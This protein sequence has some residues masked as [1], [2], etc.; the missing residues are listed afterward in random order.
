MFDLIVL[1]LF[2][3]ILY[4][5]IGWLI[6]L[7]IKVFSYLDFYW[8]TS[9]LVVITSLLLYRPELLESFQAILLC[10]LYAFWSMRLS[11]HLFQRI[12]KTGEDSRYLTLKKKWKIMY[13]VYLYGLF[14]G[15]A[16]LT[17][18]LSI[19]LFLL[20]IESLTLFN[21]LGSTL[22]T[23]ALIGEMI[24]DRQLKSFISSKNNKGKVC[25]I[26]LW[27]YSRHPNYFFETLIWLSYGVYGLDMERPI[28]FIGF[29][30]YII[31]LYLITSVTGVPAAE[32]SSLKSKGEVYRDYQKRTNR[33]LI[34]FPKKIIKHI[35]I[36]CLIG[37]VSVKELKA[38]GL[39]SQNLQAQR[40][41]KV[42]NELRADN[43]EI[44]NNFYDKQALFIDPIGEH[45]GLD[46]VKD[47]YQGIYQGVEDIRF[48]FSDIVSNGNHHV[49]V[50]RMIL[51]TP[52][53]NSGKPVILY[54]NSVIKFNE[55]GLVSYHRDYFDMGEFIY[56][57]IPLLGSLIRYIKNRLKGPQ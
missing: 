49:A 12:R 2:L 4:F 18:I 25:D 7:N 48:E 40:I 45:K 22:F 10:L 47:Y 37:G 3:V 39:D 21:F 17:V 27:K 28:T 52:N 35:L 51:V 53:L 20:S 46:A 30:P 8:S 11:T 38:T 33:F 57:H 5:T 41:E 31:M 50:W 44:L 24:A 16:V 1:V 6:S 29:I 42:F 26:G 55:S 13:G 9:F 54:G 56:E 32:E 23:I 14:I 15:E 43:I 19:P 34:W 36:I